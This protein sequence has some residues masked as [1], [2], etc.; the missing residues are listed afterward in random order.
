MKYLNALDYS[1]IVIYFVFLIGLGWYLKKKASA[2]IE[3]YFIGGRSL[4]WWALGISGMASWLDIT[5]TLLIVSFL[6]MLGPRGLYIEF[7][8]GAGLV[9]AV[10]FGRANGTGEADVLPVL[11]G[12]RTDLVVVSAVSLQDLFQLFPQLSEQ[13]E[14]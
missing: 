8:G 1:I 12:W 2:S 9:L 3:D 10:C 13:L 6:Y 5:G 11:S 14:C 4:P 7:R